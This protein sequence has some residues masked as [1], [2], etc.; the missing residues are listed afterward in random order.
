MEQRF[1]GRLEWHPDPQ[2][3]GW[4]LSFTEG[5]DRPPTV[6][7]PVLHAALEAS[8]QELQTLL[9]DAFHHYQGVLPDRISLLTSTADGSGQPAYQFEVTY[10]RADHA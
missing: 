8:Q 3:L 5:P 9:A 10:Y 6:L 1:T 2:A 7:A 4:V